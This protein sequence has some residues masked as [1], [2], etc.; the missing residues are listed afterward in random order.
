MTPWALDPRLT[1]GGSSV[2]RG[3]E[4]RTHGCQSCGG[5]W[6]TRSTLEAIIRESQTQTTAPDPRTVAR[7]ATRM[8]DEVVYRSCPVG[9]TSTRASSRA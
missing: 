9:P 1:A 4:H 7:Q 8:A 3:A 2:Y 5:T 6:V